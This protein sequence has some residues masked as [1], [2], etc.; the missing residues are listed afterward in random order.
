MAIRRVKLRLRELR[1]SEGDFV[2]EQRRL[3]CLFYRWCKGARNPSAQSVS[4]TRSTLQYP[5]GVMP[6]LQPWPRTEEPV[7]R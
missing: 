3:P 4:Q 5:A 6:A 1:A 7:L 2:L